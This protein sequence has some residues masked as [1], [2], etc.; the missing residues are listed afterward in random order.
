MKEEETPATATPQ[1]AAAL[2]AVIFLVVAS[3]AVVFQLSPQILYRIPDDSMSPILLRGTAMVEVKKVPKRGDV[4]AFYAP[5]HRNSPALIKR[6]VGEPGDTFV[7]EP[8]TKTI[9]IAGVDYAVPDCK[10]DFPV[11]YKL[12]LQEWAVFGDNPSDRQDSRFMFCENVPFLAN[13]PTKVLVKK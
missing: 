1:I 6:V 4:V 10:I 13:P 5:W 9:Q 8:V 2:L 12:G 11:S 7:Y 3:A